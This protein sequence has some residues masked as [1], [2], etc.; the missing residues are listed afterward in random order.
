MDFYLAKDIDLALDR[1]EYLARGDKISQL[2][3]LLPKTNKAFLRNWILT[4]QNSSQD[5]KN[6][7]ESQDDELNFYFG[8]PQWLYKK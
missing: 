5:G 2:S 4:K 6:D 7:K 3:D 8:D 1:A